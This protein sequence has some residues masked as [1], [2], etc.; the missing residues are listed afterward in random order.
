M[1]SEKEESFVESREIGLMS[2]DA[3][4]GTPIHDEGRPLWATRVIKGDDNPPRT[5]IYLAIILII[6]TSL[7]LITIITSDYHCEKLTIKA[8]D[9]DKLTFDN[10]RVLRISELGGSRFHYP[11]EDVLLITKSSWLPGMSTFI[12]YDAMMFSKPFPRC[13]EIKPEYHCQ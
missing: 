7:A 2:P 13:N 9:G 3:F 12:I 1:E 4:K 5:L 10:G 11:G 8:I 6:I